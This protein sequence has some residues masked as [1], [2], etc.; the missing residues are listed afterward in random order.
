MGAFD[1]GRRESCP[2]CGEDTRVCL[3]CGYYDATLYNGCR[4]NQAERVLEKNRAT[5]CDYFKPVDT[6]SKAGQGEAA[7]QAKQALEDLF[8]R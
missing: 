8:R 2:G 1:Y 3:N 5:S 4:E 6:G 7:D